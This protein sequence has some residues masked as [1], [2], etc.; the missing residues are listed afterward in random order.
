[1]PQVGFLLRIAS[2]SSLENKHALQSILRVSGNPRIGFAAIWCMNHRVS[3]SNGIPK[4]PQ[5]RALR[6]GESF[7]PKGGELPSAVGSS[8]TVGL[9]EVRRVF[10]LVIAQILGSII[11]DV[12]KPRA[13]SCQAVFLAKEFQQIV[14]KHGIAL[15][16]AF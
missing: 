14:L 16:G 12:L 4:G 15:R 13:R 6:E 5:G 11:V 7:L 8:K 3:N 1:M 10:L 9:E 2:M